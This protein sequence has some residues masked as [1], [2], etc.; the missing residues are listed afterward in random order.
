VG[1]G[2]PGTRW[3]H[4]NGERVRRVTARD[5]A[6]PPIGVEMGDEVGGEDGEP[7]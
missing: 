5:F 1:R 4:V 6:G 3:Y 7:Q 2:A